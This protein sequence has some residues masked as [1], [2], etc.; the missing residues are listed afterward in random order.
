M[1]KCLGS[2]PSLLAGSGPGDFVCRLP[3]QVGSI[4]REKPWQPSEQ[5]LRVA[6]RLGA[7]GLQVI[8]DLGDGLIDLILIDHA[9]YESDSVRFAGVNSPAGEHEVSRDTEPYFSG[10][11]R[12]D[13]CWK[14]AQT[15][16]RQ[17][18]VGSA[19]G[20]GDVAYGHEPEAP[21]YGCTVN[22][23]DDRK[24]QCVN[25]LIERR[26]TLCRE[27]VVCL[28]GLAL[29]PHPVDV[30]SSAERSPFTL[31][32][33]HSTS[34]LASGFESSV[35]SLD[36][37]LVK[38]VVEV[39]MVQEDPKDAILEVG[40]DTAHGLYIRNTPKPPWGRGAAVATESARPRVSRVSMGSSTPSSHRREVE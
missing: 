20:D 2:L 23:P 18:E 1:Q 29:P 13:D 37:I 16:L 4:L 28:A 27:L 35:E 19:G 15:D 25:G 11:V 14:Q 39:G 40:Q 6:Y 8:N 33:H 38:S 12:R 30:C 24:V 17:S 26:E 32:N 10:Y 36:H 21:A 9:M 22:S 3:G 5:T 34:R 7:T 31:E